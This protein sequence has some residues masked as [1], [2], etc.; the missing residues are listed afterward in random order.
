MRHT[1]FDRTDDH[2]ALRGLL[3]AGPDPIHVTGPPGVGVTALLD[4]FLAAARGGGLDARRLVVHGGG[5][6]EWLAA[7]AEA[8]GLG[9]SAAA[10]PRGG[11]AVVECVGPTMKAPAPLAALLAD[12]TGRG[13][14]CIVEGPA[15]PAG[16]AS[17]THAVSGIGLPGARLLAAVELAHAVDAVPDS[18]IEA[19]WRAVDGNPGAL[20]LVCA[21]LRDGAGGLAELLDRL[22]ALPPAE[23]ATA[24]AR[25]ALQ[26]VTDGPPPALW[27]ALHLPAPRPLATLLQG[28][29]P[30]R[31]DALC[32]RHLLQRRG[33]RDD[34]A[35]GRLVRAAAGGGQGAAAAEEALLGAALDFARL[36]IEHVDD[37]WEARRLALAAWPDL[38]ALEAVDAT[39]PARQVLRFELARLAVLG[40]L[41]GNAR[42][43]LD[44]IEADPTRPSGADVPR[45]ALLG[46]RV[47]LSGGDAMGA[48]LASAD[49]TLERSDLPPAARRELADGLA[50]LRIDAAAALADAGD[51]AGDVRRA[52]TAAAEASPRVSA[53]LRDEA[54]MLLAGHEAAGGDVAG[55]LECLQRTST[56]R[57]EGPA[58]AHAV[59]ILTWMAECADVLGD[60]RADEF[61]RRALRAV[62]ADEVSG[63]LA[64]RLAVLLHARRAEAAAPFAERAARDAELPADR[65]ARA[66]VIAGE[67]ARAGGHE[68]QAGRRFEAAVHQA[69]ACGEADVAADARL[70]LA[71]HALKSGLWPQAA[72]MARA[73]VALRAQR[74]AEG[75]A[76][77]RFSPARRMAD[78]E[79]FTEQVLADDSQPAHAVQWLGQIIAM[80]A[81]HL[82]PA[83]SAA[84]LRCRGALALRAGHGD[85]AR[86]D[87]SRARALAALLELEPDP[88]F[89]EL[90]R[91]AEHAAEPAT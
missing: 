8:A 11:V 56:A 82:D 14:R 64:Y 53:A 1:L 76:Q 12:L 60:P 22:D 35:C 33:P 57:G 66:M 91:A 29:E 69:D 41:S 49:V 89:D 86:R 45:L 83:L 88:A 55:A 54:L 78:L 10:G 47:A 62:R 81:E 87:L 27:S 90:L 58:S 74:A 30:A 68:A 50:R 75:D 24:C 84:A 73:A 72:E 21:R 77:A 37:P 3:S 43:L 31:V 18:A 71:V 20:R 6:G 32:G 16:I 13:F 46:A 42:G 40:G 67:A 63:A 39:G 65:R 36:V 17:R 85:P 19:L 15:A 5:D 23:R 59:E 25:F 38:L 28:G 2:L 61:A 51:D 44:R 34:L 26:A 52:L 7:A 80:A 9:P 79:V 70:G 48:L 4:A